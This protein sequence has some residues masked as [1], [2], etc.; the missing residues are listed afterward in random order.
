MFRACYLFLFFWLWKHVQ[1][2][3]WVL[4]LIRWSTFVWCGLI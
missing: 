3:C 4:I 2:S 1:S